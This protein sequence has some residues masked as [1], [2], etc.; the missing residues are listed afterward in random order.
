MRDDLASGGTLHA[1]G[2]QVH[3]PCD[4]SVCHHSVSSA[5][6][7]MP[8]YRQAWQVGDNLQPFD[9]HPEFEEYLRHFILRHFRFLHGTKV[10]IE[11]IQELGSQCLQLVSQPFLGS[12]QFV[13]HRSCARLEFVAERLKT[14]VQLFLRASCLSMQVP[15]LICHLGG[16]HLQALVNSLNSLV[17]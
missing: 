12:H 1:L 14:R 15:T 7:D 8:G 10:L 11:F 9:A 17:Q 2:V 13:A 4:A 3:A 6:V 16:K 5:I